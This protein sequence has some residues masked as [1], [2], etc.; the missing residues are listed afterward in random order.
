MK[1]K[2]IGLKTL[3]CIVPV[4]IL[5][6]SLITL[7]SYNYSIN[8]VKN[9]N[10]AKME[11]QLKAQTE[12]IENSL[13]RH[14]KIP[15]MLAKTVEASGLQLNKDNYK[16]LVTKAAGANDETFGAGIWYEPYLYNKDEKYFGPYAYKE[17]GT[18]VYTDDYNKP[19]YDYPQYDWYK[20]GK[21]T[22]ETI[23][24]S[25]PYVDEVTK[26]TMLTATAPFYDSNKNFMGVT[27][28]DIDLST[29]QKMIGNIKIGEKGKAFLIDKDGLFITNENKDKVMKAK[30]G[31]D[32][33][34]SLAELGKSMLTKKSGEGSFEDN[35]NGVTNVFYS[36]IP[37]TDW[38]IAL[39]IPQKELNASSHDLLIKLLIV[40]IISIVVAL[41]IISIF[42]NYLAK[43][44]RKIN[45]FAIKVAEGDL[46]GRLVIKSE[47]EIGKMGNY[48]NE[49][50]AGMA[51]MV[52]SIMSGSQQVS[53]ESEEL[54]ATVEEMTVKIDTIDS[55]IKNVAKV[56]Q[57][58]SATT[59]EVSASVEE[60]NSTIT[61]LSNR[62][63]EGCNISSQ[64]KERAEGIKE[65]GRASSEKGNALYEEKQ[66]KILKAMEDGKVVEEIKSMTDT[67]SG[68][69]SQ[70]N[71]L[72]LNA[73]IEAARAGEQ[74]KGFAVVAEEVRK[75]AEQS[76]QTVTSIQET[77]SKVQEAFGNLSENA[78]ELLD[79]MDNTIKNDY[80]TLMETG[81]QYQKD[82]EYIN[83]MYEDIAA[84]SEEVNATVSEVSD[85]VQSV[86]QSAYG[87]ASS[88]EEIVNSI[89]DA[90]KAMQQVTLMA[91]GQAEL[92]QE[93]RKAIERFNI[94]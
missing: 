19:E 82:S 70:T 84:M 42:S 24:W 51:N 2:S 90:S 78:R 29:L 40:M 76:S 49:M 63:L 12:A 22:N 3:L 85:A 7:F 39:T 56:I 55:S 60:I 1:I 46:S 68:I 77:V 80:R 34:K 4:F 8:T 79:F 66:L 20:I 67:I 21:N 10:K 72:A 71:L 25:Q 65:S 17:N 94:E 28:A 64:I 52:K 35:T 61:E 14:A 62:T 13:N 50:S 57:E 87:A 31:E 75:L 15:E 16:L 26:V 9:E 23:K 37:E 41:I 86:A 74:G 38:I 58:T 89:D 30:I 93:L 45:D 92:A 27:T 88:S 36:S 43:R 73:A 32:S 5:S 81:D 59:E 33:N 47:D 6:M 18:A 91:H 11:N 44:L 54:L 69:A 53:A 83:V 48:L